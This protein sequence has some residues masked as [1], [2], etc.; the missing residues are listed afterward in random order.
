MDSVLL[1]IVA[2][3]LIL[4]ASKYFDTIN[5]GS[6]SAIGVC[7]VLCGVFAAIDGLLSRLL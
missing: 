3:A 4:S 7:A 2:M 1:S 5:Q 6:W